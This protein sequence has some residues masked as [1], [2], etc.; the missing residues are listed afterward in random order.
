MKKLQNTAGGMMLA[1]CFLM[2]DSPA[3]IALAA[4]LILGAFITQEISI[5]KR[6]RK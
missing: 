2:G 3:S 1:G 5:R 6:K 4:A